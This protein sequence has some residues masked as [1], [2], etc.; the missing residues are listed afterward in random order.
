MAYLGDKI[1]C[2]C[3]NLRFRKMKP[4][5]AGFFIK[6][7]LVDCYTEN[8]ICPNCGSDIR[9][10]FTAAFLRNSPRLF[11]ANIKLLYFAPEEGVFKFLKK[12]RNISCV[13]CDIE[14]ANYS[15]YGA[16]RVDMT[17]IQFADNSFDAAIAIHVIEH[18]ENDSAAIKQLYRVI[19]PGGW[20][21]L[22]VPIS[23]EITYE[24]KSLDSQGRINAYGLAGHFRMNGLDFRKKLADNGFHVE[25]YT[26][27]DI[28][29]NYIDRQA[30]SA[31]VESD[32]YLFLCRK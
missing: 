21:L 15:R 31:H 12:Q 6:G 22:A 17:D 1:E 28:P 7:G 20:A 23:G 4:Y 32:K 19:K 26:I 18:I 3:C 11:Q 10:R 14:P 13:N 29:G 2:T 24:D 9:H 16:V 27:E 30:N 25:T 5:K 8:A